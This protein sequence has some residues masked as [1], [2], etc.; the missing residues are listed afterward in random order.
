MKKAIAI[1]VLVSLLL[2]CFSASAMDIDNLYPMTAVVT[3]FDFENDLV[4][5]TD[6]E[7]FDWIFEGI[8][9]WQIGDICS[10]IMFDNNTYE[11]VEDDIIV[12]IVYAG[13][14]EN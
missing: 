7:G 5:V 13:F 6:Y 8:E 4:I 2:V 10:M 9:D 1:L 11:Y 14:M 12:K 3:D